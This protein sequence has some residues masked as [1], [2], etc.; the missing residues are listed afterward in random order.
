MFCFRRI[1]LLFFYFC[2]VLCGLQADSTRKFS[3]L[4]VPTFGY[5]PETRGYAGAV[6]QMA[7]KTDNNPATRASAL[8]TEFQ[9]TQNKQLIAEM[10]GTLFAP[11]EKGI[12]NF[13]LHRSRFPEYFWGIGINT[14]ESDKILIDNDRTWVDLAGLFQI[15]KRWFAGPLFRYQKRRLNNIQMIG[16]AE[17]SCYQIGTQL[18]HDSRNNIL[19]PQMGSFFDLQISNNRSHQNGVRLL[20]DYRHYFTLNKTSVLALRG[21][22]SWLSSQTYFFDLALLG[23]DRLLRAYYA[24]RF[25]DQGLFVMNLEYRKSFYRRW[26][27]AVGAGAGSVYNKPADAFNNPSKPSVNAGIRFLADR[28]ERINL[29]IDYALGVNGQRGFYFAFGE[30]F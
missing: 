22:F 11:G 28:K 18:L 8:K 26:G 30:A 7:F 3:V 2:T 4:P 12:L 9:Y 6:V 19:N 20:A 25:R 27:M 16:S 23:G 29:R 13:T 14:E 24:G 17:F 1:V 10:S 15:R 21:A 5:A